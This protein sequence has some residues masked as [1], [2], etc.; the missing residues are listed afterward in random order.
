[1]SAPTID[2]LAAA[3][4]AILRHGNYDDLDQRDSREKVWDRVNPLVGELR[5]ALRLLAAYDE[6]VK[7]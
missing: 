5:N 2:E 3:L 4:R 1:M 7:Q 6:A